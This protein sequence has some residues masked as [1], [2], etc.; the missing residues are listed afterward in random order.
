LSGPAEFVARGKH[1][2]AKWALDDDAVDSGRGEGSDVTSIDESA[3]LDQRLADRDVFA[4]PADIGVCGN[5]AGEEDL[6]VS[7][8]A[9]LVHYYGC[10]ARRDWGAGSEPDGLANMEQRVGDTA[11]GDFR[12]DAIA[13]QSAR[14]AE[15]ISIHGGV[16]EARE[17]L[18]CGDRTGGNPAEGAEQRE[19]LRPRYWCG[20][21]NDELAGIRWR[22]QAQC[23]G[24]AA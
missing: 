24:L 13:G 20:V 2:D 5:R 1:R 22:Y 18:R 12:N 7:H 23:A 6:I 14:R 3:G 11:R 4:S 10:H 15:P 8:A 16:V 19:S 17:G 21:F 9:C